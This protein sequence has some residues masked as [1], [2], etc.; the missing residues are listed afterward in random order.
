MTART[1]YLLLFA[2]L[3][4]LVGASLALPVLAQS[5]ANDREAA[6]ILT[7]APDRVAPGLRPPPG[8]RQRRAYRRD[9]RDGGPETRTG[10]PARDPAKDHPKRFRDRWHDRLGGIAP[11]RPGPGAPATI[12]S[13][14]ARLEGRRPNPPGGTLV[15]PGPRPA[16]TR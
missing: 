6:R 4:A 9:H 3:A 10:R 2:A 16:R 15:R 7:P 1:F 13:G 8:E 5:A 14:A 12:R 11:G